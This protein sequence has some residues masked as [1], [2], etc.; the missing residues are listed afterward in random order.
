MSG[1]ILFLDLATTLGWAEGVPG[2]KP[3]YGGHRLAP[4]SSAQRAVFGGMI[5]WLGTR[6]QAFRPRV[7][8][9]EAPRDPRHMGKATNF[10]TARSLIGLCAVVEGVCDRMG[11]YD[12]READV[13]EIRK[14]F[15]PAGSPRTGSAVKRAVI[16][17]CRRFGYDPADDNVAD[18]LAGWH[19]VSSVL[20]PS[21][22]ATTTPL[23]RDMTR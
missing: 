11:V 13:N 5:Q 22:A 19:F 21:T 8:V 12:V 7:V 3:R 18:A 10:D 1:E 17:Q 20:S 6:L 9:Y 16:Q 4:P 2:E 14:H 23:F 15:L